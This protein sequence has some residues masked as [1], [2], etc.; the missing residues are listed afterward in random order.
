LSEDT[1]LDNR[2]YTEVRMVMNDDS[3]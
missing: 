1:N 2:D 3:E